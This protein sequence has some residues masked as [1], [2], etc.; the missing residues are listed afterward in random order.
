[1]KS[2]LVALLILIAVMLSGCF[3]RLV[4]REGPYEFRQG[5]DQVVSIEILD[6]DFDYEGNANN[7][8][9]T[10]D[11]SMHSEVINGLLE[12]PGIRIGLDP[13]T[14]FG[15]YIFRIT[16]QNGER[17]LIGR[18]NNGYITPKGKLRVSNYCFYTEPFEEFLFGVLGE[19][20][21]DGSAYNESAK[22]LGTVPK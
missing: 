8:L 11:P 14:T 15:P 20:P 2:R 1:M 17:E 19:I 4:N 18:D 22:P 21:E 7:V 3:L 10:I 12:L 13:S 16:Y 6:I 9:M 5:L